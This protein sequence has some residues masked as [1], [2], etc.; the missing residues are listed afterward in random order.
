MKQVIDNIK[1]LRLAKNLTQK[2][3]AEKLGITTQ[4]Y[5]KLESGEND[6]TLT[7]LE[8]IAEVHGVSVVSLFEGTESEMYRK[9]IVD[10]NDRIE[11]LKGQKKLCEFEKQSLEKRVYSAENK[12]ESAKSQVVKLK[13]D[14]LEQ[15]ITQLEKAQEHKEYL[16]A[17]RTILKIALDEFL[18][19]IYADHNQIIMQIQKF[20]SI[21][22]K[23]MESENTI[24]KEMEINNPYKKHF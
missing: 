17:C 15:K 3:L 23:F 12:I 4:G 21:T 13:V 19:D 18:N 8:Q 20:L 10:L 6:F 5:Q 22:E 11:E 7:R 1:A 2:D 14:L 16:E 9:K 24:L